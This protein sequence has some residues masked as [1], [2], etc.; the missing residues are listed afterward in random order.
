MSIESR[1]QSIKKKSSQ[2][3]VETVVDILVPGVNRILVDRFANE[4]D[5]DIECRLAEG[6]RLRDKSHTIRDKSR[7]LCISLSILLSA[8]LLSFF[9]VDILPDFLAHFH[10]RYGIALEEL[11][12]ERGGTMKFYFGPNLILQVFWLIIPIVLWLYTLYTSWGLIKR[13][14]M[15][16]FLTP[17][18]VAL[19]VFIFSPL[20]CSIG[21]VDGWAEALII[22]G[23]DVRI[24]KVLFYFIMGPV[25]IIG[26]IMLAIYGFIGSLF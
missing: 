2:S 10:T 9:P 7:V 26:E 14:N 8:L 1:K 6:Y 19:T 20:F 18:L 4:S 13:P 16:M 23:V 25:L 22:M 3:K 21:F 11:A 24:V 15:T 5:L 17:K 12:V